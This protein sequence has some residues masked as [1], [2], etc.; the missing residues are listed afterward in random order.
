MIR[1][2]STPAGTTSASGSTTGTGVVEVVALPPVSLTAT[3][4]EVG[5]GLA[6][7]EQLRVLGEVRR[8]RR[9]RLSPSSQRLADRAWATDMLGACCCTTF[10]ATWAAIC[11]TLA[12]VRPAADAGPP[13]ASRTRD[14]QRQH[15]GKPPCPRAPAD[16][17]VEAAG[18]VD[19]EEAHVVRALVGERVGG[20]L[21]H[22]HVGAG[23]GAQHP[24]VVADGDRERPL[25]HQ[26]GVVLAA[27]HVALDA[28]PGREHHDAR[29]KNGVSTV[30]ARNSTLPTRSP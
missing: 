10:V 9:R 30:R 29:L 3:P 22:Q 28:L 7:V 14:D 27:V 23:P 6:A 25:E 19:V 18:R 11:C 17:P 16:P 15:S 1:S 24:A 21:G 4:V 5:P 12:L 13:A 2:A 20:A 26:P 8:A